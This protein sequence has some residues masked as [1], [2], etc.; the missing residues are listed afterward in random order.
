VHVARWV[1]HEDVMPHAAAV[2]CHGGAGTVRAA[3]ASGV[4]MVVLALLA[5]SS[6][7]NRRYV[8]GGRGPSRS[9]EVSTVASG[10]CRISSGVS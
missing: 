6:L 2:I 1:P 10:A 5:R 4:P 7:K 3:L 9:G 8:R